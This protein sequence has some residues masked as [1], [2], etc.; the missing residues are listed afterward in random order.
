MQPGDLTRAS[1]A[2]EAVRDDRL[3]LLATGIC[4]RPIALD[5]GDDLCTDGRSI[6]FVPGVSAV[7]GLVLQAALL[8]VGSFPAHAVARL[9]ARPGLRRRYLLL[10]SRRAVEVLGAVLPPRTVRRVL[11]AYDGQVPTDS[12]A[13]L[14]LAASTGRAIPDAPE[15]MGVI[16]PGKL[17]RANPGSGGSPPTSAELARTPELAELPAEDEDGEESKFLKL[18]QAPVGSRNPISSYLQK[19][20]GIGSS[21]GRSSAGGGGEMP[22]GGYRAAMGNPGAGVVVDASSVP[23]E[24][25]FE[26]APR[27]RLYPEWDWFRQRYRENWC[28]V[29]EYDPRIEESSRFTVPANV[30]LRRELARIGMTPERHRRQSDG[31]NLDLDAIVDRRVDRRADRRSGSE[32]GDDRVYERQ[33]RTAHDLGVLILLDATGSTGES[34]DETRI[35]DEQRLVAAELTAEFDSLGVRVASYAFQSWGRQNVQFLRIKGYDD[36]YDSAAQQRLGALSPGGFTRLGAAIRHGA[37]VARAGSGAS[38]NLVVVVGDG[39]PYDDGY[40]NRYAQEDSRRALAEAVEV[41]VAAACL[42]VRTATSGAALDRVWGSVPFEALDDPIELASKVNEL[43]RRALKA[44][45]AS[46]RRIAE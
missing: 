18:L 31:D 5:E 29:T 40:E 42:S 32:A 3:S 36:R 37:H 2:P 4:G 25:R 11:A 26:P 41:G 13:S 46:R 38:T 6:Y 15:W 23:D 7:D 39:L 28:T 14:Q 45:A 22:V 12:R 24:L 19:L 30:R 17:L 27:G 16:K 35:F 9:A 43:F 21:P 44:A 10:E 33:L 8:A 1:G 34:G 20:L